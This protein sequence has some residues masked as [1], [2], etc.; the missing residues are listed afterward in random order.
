VELVFPVNEQQPQYEWIEGLPF[1]TRGGTT[2]NYKLPGRCRVRLLGCAERRR[3]WY[4][5]ETLYAL[6]DGQIVQTIRLPG[7]KAQ[8]ERSPEA[9]AA[10]AR[11]ARLA[12]DAIEAVKYFLEQKKPTAAIAEL[13]GVAPADVDAIAYT[14]ANGG[15]NSLLPHS[16]KGGPHDV[17]S[18]LPKR[19]SPCSKGRASRSRRL[20]PRGWWG[21]AAALRPRSQDRR[22][23]QSGRRQGHAEP[24]EDLRVPSR[25]RGAGAGC[26]RR[27]SSAPRAR[28][29][30]RPA[31][32]KDLNVLLTF[33]KDART[34]GRR[35]HRGIE[36]ACV[37]C[38]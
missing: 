9:V 27:A 25:V 37:A 10:D 29:Y 38:W 26:V 7:R 24:G 16:V 23:L 18:P 21:R 28:A 11:L 32:E 33:Y 35:I 36:P 20:G 8:A 2:F 31:T 5:T 22:A 15:G 12:P 17:A 6:V 14:V 1:G 30:R 34:A 4:L 3:N 13:M 19:C